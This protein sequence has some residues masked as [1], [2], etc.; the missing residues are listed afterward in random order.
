M[1]I[2]ELIAKLEKMR[3]DCGNVQVK[4]RRVN[5]DFGDVTAV[6]VTHYGRPPHPNAVPARA[7]YLDV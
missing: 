7:V 6:A 2:N 3:A 5:G 4:V 1:S